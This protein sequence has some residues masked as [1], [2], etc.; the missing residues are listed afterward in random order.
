MK[1]K[2]IGEFVRD[3]F[4]EKRITDPQVANFLSLTTSAVEKIYPQDDMYISRLIKLSEIAN[5]DF[6]E[7]YYDKEP[8]KR[9]RDNEIERVRTELESLKTDLKR[10]NDHIKNLEQMNLVQQQLINSLTV[11]ASNSQLVKPKSNKKSI[12]NKK[13]TQA[14]KQ[15]EK[16]RKK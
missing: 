1:Q 16:T 8:L 6:F 12:T 3:R 2:H 13:N 15:I 5:E 11:E 7:F 14:G 9:L 10:M 4:R